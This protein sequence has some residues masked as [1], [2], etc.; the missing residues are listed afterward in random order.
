MPKEL[1]V[2][3]R[4]FIRNVVQSGKIGQSAVRAG[5]HDSNYGSYLMAQPHIMT[6]LQKAMDKAGITDGEVANKLKEGL[7]AAYPE[8]LYKDGAVKQPAAPDFH[9]RKEYL[10][11][12]LKVRGDYAPERVQ[13]ETRQVTLN[14]TMN[15]AQ[16]LIESG[17]ITP[18]EFE[19]LKEV[20]KTSG[21]NQQVER[22]E[23]VDRKLP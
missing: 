14:I 22:S 10:D 23:L 7:S 4:K 20:E 6:A 8:Q 21:D 11:I 13:V 15:M 2:R 18:A 3:D 16:G 9:T 19:E 5:F 1:T 17:A 12:A